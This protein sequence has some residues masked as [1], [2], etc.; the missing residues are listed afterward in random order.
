[1]GH[2][3]LFI[4]WL[5]SSAPALPGAVMGGAWLRVGWSV[6]LACAVALAMRRQ[7]IAVRRAGAAAAVLWVLLPG[8]ASPAHWLGLAFQTPSLM[9]FALCV[10]WLWRQLGRVSAHTH[11]RISSPASPA[12]AAGVLTIAAITLGW[13]L[14][15]DTWG[16]WATSVYAWGF[17]PAALALVAVALAVLWLVSSGGHAASLQPQCVLVALVLIAY[18]GLRLP[19]GNLWDALLDPWLWVALQVRFIQGLLQR[20]S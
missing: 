11:A 7:G 6:V 19:T 2:T 4:E 16:V 12:P 9:A 5:A 13:V 18:A 14:G 15:L 8:P 10:W 17:G 1:M 20:R 3:Q